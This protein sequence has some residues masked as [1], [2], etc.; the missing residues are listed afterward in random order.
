MRIVFYYI[1][2]WYYLFIKLKKMKGKKL[3][4]II[5]KARLSARFDIE[6]SNNFNIGFDRNNDVDD[7]LDLH[8]YTRSEASSLLNDFI[9]FCL[10]NNLSKV[11]IITGVGEDS[12][13]VLKGM[14]IDYLKENNYRFNQSS[15]N[16]GGEGAFDVWL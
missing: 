13:S 11:R 12:Y 15:Q 10:E 5:N 3:K 14:V 6:R 4:K 9:D 8:G 1:I 16:R 2:L 7:S